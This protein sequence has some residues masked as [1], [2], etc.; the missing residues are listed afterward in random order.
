MERIMPNARLRLIGTGALAV[1]VLLSAGPSFSSAGQDAQHQVAVVNVEIPVRVF[2]GDAFVDSLGF[3]DFEVLDN[4]VPQTIEAI[5]LIHKTEIART[6]GR[7]GNTPQVARQF[8]LFF[9]LNEF[10]PEVDPALDMFF[11]KVY[12]PGDSLIV[13]TP[14][15]RYHLRAEAF[16]ERPRSVIKEEL[17]AKLLRDILIGNTEYQ[18]LLRSLKSSMVGTASFEE[19]LQLYSDTLTRLES[20]RRV[21]E[22]GLLEFAGFLRDLPGQKTV[23]IFYQKERVPSYDWKALMS[24][25]DE[26]QADAATTFKLMENFQLF[27]RDADIDVG[28]IKRAYAE[29]SISVHFLFLTRTLPANADIEDDGSSGLTMVEQSAD[30]FSAFREVAAATGGTTDSSA[31]MAASFSRAIDATEN[32]YLI[33]FKPKNYKVDGSFHTLTVRVTSGKYRLAYREGYVAR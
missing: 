22:K 4:G 28:A 18:G 24:M 6:E 7:P 11:D 13:V 21:N 29:S 20:M 25:M 19:K 26:N 3:K 33:Y 16:R 5:Y 8:V 10:I 17:K 27:H 9:E 32:Y 30:I 15:N 2:R 14:A 1:I 23:F 31:N 12:L